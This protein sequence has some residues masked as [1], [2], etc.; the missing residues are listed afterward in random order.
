MRWTGGQIAHLPCSKRQRCR[1]KTEQNDDHQPFRRCPTPGLEQVVDAECGS[2]VEPVVEPVV[3]RPM[4]IGQPAPAS[5]SFEA[6]RLPD[7]PL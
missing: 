3:E 7:V 5:W 4:G 2:A 1:Q 6:Q